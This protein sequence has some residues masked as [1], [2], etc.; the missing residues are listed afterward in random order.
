M[1]L[2]AKFGNFGSSYFFSSEGKNLILLSYQSQIHVTKQ[3]ESADNEK[4]SFLDRVFGTKVEKATQAHSVLLADQQILYELQSKFFC[5][6]SIQFCI[7]KNESFFL[8]S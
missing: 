3:L 4:T 7:V 1:H 6:N 8:S 5:L 2:S